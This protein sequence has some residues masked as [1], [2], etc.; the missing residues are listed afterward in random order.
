VIQPDTPLEELTFVVFD[1][2]T[3][4]LEPGHILQLAFVVVRG[5]GEVVEQHRTYIK[6]RFWRPG[7]LGAHHVHGI[8]RR[9]LR[10]G[11]SIADALAALER[12]CVGAIP[13]AH[14]A[15]FDLTFLK[16]ECARLGRALR[17]E[18]TLCTLRLSRSLDPGRSR[19]HKL[20]NLVAHY[21]LDEI[22][23]HDALADA[24]ATAAILP[25]LMRDRGITRLSEISDYRE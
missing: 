24:L 10:T 2:E 13:V 25:C 16:A 14:N 7:R 12:A 21:G 3:T 22:P 17:L 9:H 20:A 6:R 5:N 23:N 1:T 8:T 18:P 4:G 11:T 19:R 15:S